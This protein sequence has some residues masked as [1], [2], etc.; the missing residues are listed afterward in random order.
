MMMT[1]NPPAKK[2]LV[3]LRNLRKRID[4]G[5]RQVGHNPFNMT[6]NTSLHN[7]PAMIDVSVGL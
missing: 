4:T 3:P 1:S 2:K 5:D 7:C 6:L